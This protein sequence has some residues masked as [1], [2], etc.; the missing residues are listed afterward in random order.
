MPIIPALRRQR[1]EDL[2]EFKVNL[3][4]TVISHL[5]KKKKPK[6][7]EHCRVDTSA[8]GRWESI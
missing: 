1:L 8:A 4:Y 3:G 6:P 7:F 5:K 2:W